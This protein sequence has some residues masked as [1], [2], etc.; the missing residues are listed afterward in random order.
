MFLSPNFL[1]PTVDSSVSVPDPCRRL[2][3]TAGAWNLYLAFFNP[4]IEGYPDYSS[5]NSG[6]Y[7]CNY[8]PAGNFVGRPLLKTGPACSG[9][10]VGA[11]CEDGLCSAAAMEA[12][13][14]AVSTTEPAAV[15][16]DLENASC[17]IKKV[18][19]YLERCFG[20]RK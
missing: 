2:I 18:T 10:P 4:C 7:V 12:T 8:G 11:T 3:S 13:T 17:S 14:V 9:C 5:W 19:E 16:K 15:E 6:F 1:E 20:K